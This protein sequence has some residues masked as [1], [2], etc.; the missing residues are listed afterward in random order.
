MKQLNCAMAIILGVGL[1]LAP[2]AA[3]ADHHE[4]AGSTE[5]KKTHAEG[6]GGHSHEGATQEGKSEVKKAGASEADAAAGH[7]HD[8]Q[9]EEEKEGSH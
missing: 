7:G 4:K 3:L 8:T 9:G 1:A 6:N 5:E 2:M